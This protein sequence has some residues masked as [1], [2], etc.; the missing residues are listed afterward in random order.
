MS[1]WNVI[2]TAGPWVWIG[3]V[4]AISFLEAPLK[5]RAPGITVEL[6]VGIGRL[7]FRALNAVEFVLAVA[8]AVS[9]L[10]GGDDS[11]G[12]WVAWAIAAL[13]LVAKGLLRGAMDRR[14]RR[15][16]GHHLEPSH[17]L[18]ILYL[19][20]EVATVLALGT[21]GV[22]SLDLLVP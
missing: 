10:A 2:Q 12:I 4:L 3:M 1:T 5:F 9:L 13:A 20:A 15:V 8:I 14:A 18:H 11:S 16:V 7:V 21:L 22:L 19:L 6:G 17:R